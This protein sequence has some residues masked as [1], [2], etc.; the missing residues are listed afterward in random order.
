MT[1]KTDL[2]TIPSAV[3]FAREQEHR[4]VAG[5]NRGLRHVH[6]RAALAAETAAADFCRAQGLAAEGRE[7]CARG[8]HDLNVKTRS[9]LGSP[10]AQVC[11]RPGCTYVE[12][13]APVKPS[14]ED[15]RKA[16]AFHEGPTW[17]GDSHSKVVASMIRA[18]AKRNG[19]EL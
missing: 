4:R 16:L 12:K 1:D 14:A 18:D 3:W 9:I 15:Y 19:V 17:K 6:N 2:T 5:I 11:T 10:Q 7:K 8:E 13:P